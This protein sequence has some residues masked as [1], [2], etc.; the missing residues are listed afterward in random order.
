MARK[1]RKGRPSKKPST[2]EK[3]SYKV[4][5]QDSG[6]ESEV[7]E[8]ENLP[9]LN[10]IKYSQSD[11]QIIQLQQQNLEQQQEIQ[12]LKQMHQQTNLQSIQQTQMTQIAA[13]VPK[14]PR[15]P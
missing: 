5:N 4:K 15:K 6:D 1:G 9:S 7:S 11:D 3:P 10:N 2:I 14:K 8:N 13:E 12:R